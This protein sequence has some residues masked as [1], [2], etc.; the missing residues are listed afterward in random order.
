MPIYIQPELEV[1]D[2]DV[3]KLGTNTEALVSAVLKES[4]VRCQSDEKTG[5]QMLQVQSIPLDSRECVGCPSS[6][7]AATCMANSDSVPISDPFSLI[8]LYQVTTNFKLTQFLGKD[9]LS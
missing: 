9:L 7:T 4:C 3:S 8:H 5:W 2:D 6:H 1:G